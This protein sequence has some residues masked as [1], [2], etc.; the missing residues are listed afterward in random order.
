M[1]GMQGDIMFCKEANFLK[2]TGSISLSCKHAAS[3][4]ELHLVYTFK[5]IDDIH[6]FLIL[7]CFANFFWGGGGGGGGG[8]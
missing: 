4:D 7:F 5:V 3:P 6:P 8:I 2:A 1:S